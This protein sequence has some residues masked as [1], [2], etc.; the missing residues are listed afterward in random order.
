MR[1]HTR[2]GRGQAHLRPD[3]PRQVPREVVAL[4]SRRSRSSSRR[5]LQAPCAAKRAAVAPSR[6]RPCPRPTAR[7]KPT[8][9]ASC[10]VVASAKLRTCEIVALRRGRAEPAE[11]GRGRGAVARLSDG[12]TLLRS[13]KAAGAVR[14]VVAALREHRLH[15]LEQATCGWSDVGAWRRPC[16]SPPQSS[17]ESRT[18]DKV[19]PLTSGSLVTVAGESGLHHEGGHP[20]RLKSSDPSS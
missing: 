3:A 9:R 5:A 16:P 7:S 20:A 17:A 18:T 8:K 2:S 15:G 1:V 13:A 11:R 4:G 14:R 10:A 6:A 19:A 12:A